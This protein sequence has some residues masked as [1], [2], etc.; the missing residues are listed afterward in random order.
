MIYII[1]SDVY[2]Y[3]IYIYIIYILYHHIHLS[4]NGHVGCFHVLSIVNSAYVTIGV[5][6]SE[7]SDN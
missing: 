7:K 1:Y 6:V 2:I 3:I 4:V 5:N